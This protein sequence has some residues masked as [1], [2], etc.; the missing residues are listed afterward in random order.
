MIIDIG[1][2]CISVVIVA[3]AATDSPVS[4]TA[5]SA[6]KVVVRVA[7]V[8]GPID[9]SQIVTSVPDVA[10]TDVAGA[11]IRSAAAA[12]PTLTAAT[13][14]RAIAAANPSLTAAN[15]AGPIAAANPSLTAATL[16][17]PIAA[18][19]PSLTAATEAGPVA[20]ADP[21]L[22]AAAGSG[23]ARSQVSAPGPSHSTHRRPISTH[24]RPCHGGTVGR[25]RRT[26][27]AP[28]RPR[29]PAPA[30]WSHSAAARR[31]SAAPTTALCMGRFRETNRDQ[32]C[33]E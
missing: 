26:C 32:A 3:H 1:N 13:D 27:H 7:A 31:P 5:A 2:I 10:G 17:G 12:D 4:A 21:S 14:R 28:G 9:D 18:A 24:R 6:P 22:T 19:N 30:A 16:A 25:H 15:E 20:A 29:A 23:A 11:D 8:V 33:R